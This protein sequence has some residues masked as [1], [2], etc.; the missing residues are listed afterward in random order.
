MNLAYEP[1]D[2]KCAPFNID[3]SGSSTGEE[4]APSPTEV[5]NLASATF[6]STVVIAV[7]AVSTLM[8]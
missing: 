7:G 3:G 4:P 2:A 6:M 1:E 5:T 8:A